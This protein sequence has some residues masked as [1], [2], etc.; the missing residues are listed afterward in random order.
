[1]R[2]N[3][4]CSDA[5]VVWVRAVS[6]S[7]GSRAA[8]HGGDRLRGRVGEHR[9]ARS[10]GVGERG[11]AELGEHAHAVPA[12]DLVHVDHAI[13]HEDH[14]VR[15]LARHGPDALEMRPGGGAQGGG[16]RRHAARQLEHLQAEPVAAVRGRL[17][18]IAAIRQ[19]RQQAVRGAHHEARARRRPPTRRARLRPRAPRGRRALGRRT[20][21]ARAAASSCRQRRLPGNRFHI[22]GSLISAPAP[23]SRR[24]PAGGER[25]GSRALH[26]SNSCTLSIDLPIAASPR[27][28]R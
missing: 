3:S 13:T 8:V 28:R 6:R 25:L 11:A 26:G 16:L 22:T 24:A 7:S 23:I 4:S 2:A 14:Q 17:P 19:A 20:A 1:M 18:H 12:G 15:G 21:R 27:A 5:S 9:L 10:G